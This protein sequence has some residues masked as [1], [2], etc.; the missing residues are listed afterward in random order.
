MA[1]YCPEN[2][3][4]KR[5]Y[6]L[7]LEAADGKQSATADVALRAIERFEIS[8]GWAPF[9]KF[10]IEQARKFRQDLREE[11]GPAGKPLSAATIVSTLKCLRGFFLWLSREPGYRS[12]LNANDAAYFR[13]A[14][15]DVRIATAKREKRVATLDEVKRVLALMPSGSVIEKR[16]RALVACAILTGARDGAL[17]SLRL[18]HIDLIART[19]FQDGRD[20]KTKRRKTFTSNFFPVGPEPLDILAEYVALLRNDL[21][22]SDDD[23]LFPATQMGRGADR[24]FAAVGLSRESWRGAAPIRKV[25]REAFAAAG[26]AYANPHSFRNTLTRL[27]E[28]LC[29]TPEE[30]KVWSQNLG[31][32]SE[33]TTFVGYGHVPADR[34]AEI[35]RALGSPRPVNLPASFDF[36]ALKA[37]LQSVESS[38]TK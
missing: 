35:M 16:T 1:K 13:P 3:R 28:R 20:V 25:F 2:E 12:A 38:D 30:W 4:M 24:A 7:F 29:R 36:A 19:L 5:A 9:K 37:L 26:L 27:G 14:D 18:K 17:A 21:G 11:I 6:T 32:E 8:T 15:Q 23:P 31:H 22:F 34:H 10:H 33:A